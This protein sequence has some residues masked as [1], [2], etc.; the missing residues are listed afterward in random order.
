M[1]MT[2]STQGI[3]VAGTDTG[4]GKTVLAAMLLLALDGWYWKPV[5]SGLEEETD[6][7]AVIRMTGLPASR[8]LPEGYRLA[9]PLSPDQ[10]AAYDGVVIDPARLNLPRAGG[11][12]VIEGAGGLMVP[13]NGNLLQI[14]LFASWGMPVVLAARS[15]LGTLN[16]TLLSVE[17]LRLRG[18]ATCG[19]V[20]IGPEN[21]GN[22]SSL[23]RWAG[24]PVL[25]VIPP[26]ARLDRETLIG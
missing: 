13:L 6:T 21:M 25:G 9:R 5:Q 17:A 10:S 11:R 20:M 12:L 22:R 3:I 26:L 14:D 19:V 18:V 24:V 15:G 4:I 23:E 8:A 7:D 16:H 2:E 1:S